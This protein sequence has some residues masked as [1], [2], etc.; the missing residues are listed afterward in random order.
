ML[1]YA[2]RKTNRLQYIIDFISTETG[3]PVR[4]STDKEGFKN[5]DGPRINYSSTRLSNE[6]L[7]I[8]PAGLLFE[9]L[10]VPQKLNPF[11]SQE[12]PAF[13]PC[14]EADFRFDLLAA[15][16]YLLSRYEEYLPHRTNM[17]GCYA[18]EDSLAFKEDFIHLPIVNIWIEELKK[19]VLSKWPALKGQSQ[20]FRFIPTYDIDTAWNYKHKGLRRNLGS[21]ARSIT[22]LDLKS[23]NKQIAVLKNEQ[24]DPFEAYDWIE[25]IHKKYDQQPLYFFLLAKKRT[26]RDKNIP[27]HEK[28]FQQLIKSLAEKFAIGIHPSW[29]SG[30]QEELLL[31]EK[32]RLEEITS[33]KVINS[34]QHYIRWKLPG[35][36]R[37]LIDAEI[38]NDFSMGYTTINGF[39]ASVASPFHWYDLP[40]ESATPLRL[41]PFCFMDSTAIFEQ[42]TNV[43]DASEELQQYLATIKKLNGTMITVFHNNYLGTDERFQEWKK[44]YQDF[45]GNVTGSKASI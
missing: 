20:Q 10:I 1:L 31:E 44:M 42:E 5:H 37:Q 8:Q 40:A 3:W 28:N 17:Y 9:S 19:V 27:P 22:Q 24:P 14:R 45:L 26:E 6:E 16:F 7:W 39:R 12:F 2:E 30:D 38:E 15:A 21:I 36:F 11:K 32:Q 23:I 18:H 34:R 13:Y 29:E 35:S 25:S 33:T 4:L 41:W 43:K